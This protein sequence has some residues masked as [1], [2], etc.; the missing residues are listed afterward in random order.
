VCVAPSHKHATTYPIQH[1]Y[2]NKHTTPNNTNKTKQNKTPTTQTQHRLLR[3]KALEC[4]SLVGMAVG[5]ERF[6][7]DA[8]H[9]MQFLRGLQGAELDADDPTSSYVLQAGARLC[10]ALGPEFLP[11]LDVVMPPL[12]R[13]AALEPDVK[14]CVRGFVG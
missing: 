8:G 4:V 7:A 5:R 14:V 1:T 9:V 3:A 13:A 2:T 6:R 10:R 12:L 11:Y